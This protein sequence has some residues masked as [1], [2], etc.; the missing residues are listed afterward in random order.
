MLPISPPATVVNYALG[1]YNALCNYILRHDQALDN[2]AIERLLCC[3]SL[4]R[5]PCFAEAMPELKE[6][7]R[8]IRWLAPVYSTG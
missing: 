7:H 5:N 6:R 4:S 3:I 8:S 2:N 1:E